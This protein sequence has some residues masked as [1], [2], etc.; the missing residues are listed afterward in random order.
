MPQVYGNVDKGY[1]ICKLIHVLVP[2]LRNDT[3]RL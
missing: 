1:T 2:D 3:N